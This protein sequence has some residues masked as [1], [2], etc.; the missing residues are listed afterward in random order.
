[1]TDYTRIIENLNNELYEKF[2]ETGSSFGYSTNGY[3]HLI[4]FDQNVLWSSDNDER[5]WIEEINDK[6]SLE[7]HIKKLFNMLA[8]KIY[9]LKFTKT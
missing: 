1:M 3:A 2:N 4:F 9:R 7:P 6:E 8:D 5:E